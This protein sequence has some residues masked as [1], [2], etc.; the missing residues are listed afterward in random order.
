MSSPKTRNRLGYAAVCLATRKRERKRDL[1]MRFR[2]PDFR[3]RITLYRLTPV[4]LSYSLV[5]HTTGVRGIAVLASAFP[6]LTLT[7]RC[8]GKARP[9]IAVLREAQDRGARER[10]FADCTTFLEKVA[11][12]RIRNYNDE[13]SF[14]RREGMSRGC[15]NPRMAS[16]FQGE[17]GICRTALTW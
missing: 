13:K 6:Q 15:I 11:T 4:C 5:T 3:C 16:E 2:W 17:G 14:T 1:G 9:D 7:S 12:P 10:D 8:A